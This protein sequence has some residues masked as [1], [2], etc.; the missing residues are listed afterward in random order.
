M[1][2]TSQDFHSYRLAPLPPLLPSLLSL[3]LCPS[4]PLALCPLS[5]SLLS[6][7]L[8]A[9]SYCSSD[10]LSLC[11]CLSPSP[12]TGKSRGASIFSG[13]ACRNTLTKGE[14]VHPPVCCVSLTGWR[15]GLSANHLEMQAHILSPGATGRPSTHR[16]TGSCTS[17]LLGG[18]ERLC[19]VW[20]PGFKA[21]IWMEN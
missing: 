11:L 16:Y 8:S 5:L 21:L 18:V 17:G 3:S 1:V 9:P 6:L 14:W 4:L 7:L 20:M 19:G 10:S 15:L 13:S 2:S 12:R